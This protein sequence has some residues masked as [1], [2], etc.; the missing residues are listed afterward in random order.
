MRKITAGVLVAFMSAFYLGCEEDIVGKNEVL[1]DAGQQQPRDLSDTGDNS[2]VR[3]ER[4]DTDSNEKIVPD[5]SRDQEEPEKLQINATVTPSVKETQPLGDIRTEVP[6]NNNSEIEYLKSKSFIN[7]TITPT[8]KTDKS[9]LMNYITLRGRTI[10]TK[11]SIPQVKKSKTIPSAAAPMNT[12]TPE[13]LSSN[14]QIIKPTI[15]PIVGGGSKTNTS[16]NIVTRTPNSIQAAKTKIVTESYQTATPVKIP[17][18]NGRP[19]TVT[20]TPTPTPPP[21][22]TPTPTFTPT[23]TP[24]PTYLNAGSDDRYGV[25]L[26]NLDKVTTESFLR[27]LGVDW[28]YGPNQGLVNVPSGAKKILVTHLPLDSAPWNSLST[29]SLDEETNQSIRD[30][31]FLDRNQIQSL[32]IESPGSYWYLYGELNR[33]DHISGELF[34]EVFY[35]YQKQIR[36]N[37]PSAKIIGPSILNWAYTCNGC[38]GISVC[39]DM[40]VFG[41]QCGKRWV[42]NF[43]SEYVSKYDSPPIVDIWAIDAYP[44]DWIITPNT[45]FHAD[46]AIEQIEQYRNFLDT[47]QFDGVVPYLNDP[48]WVMEIGVHVG[49]DGWEF[50][51]GKINPV[52]DYNW[53]EMGDYLN[54]VLGWLDDNS[55]N[56]NIGKWFVYRSWVD[57]VNVGPDGYMGISLFDHHELTEQINC[58]GVIFKT[59]AQDSPKVSCSPNGNVIE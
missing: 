13:K 37:D 26:H 11:T 41:Y 17:L 3:N 9:K 21:T 36:L 42:E 51:N 29:T 50:E 52:G 15:T 6:K 32:A 46:I 56:L 30:M 47:Y 18:Y 8:T 44:I 22:P 43:L 14:L 24:T 12:P 23:V 34:A 57:V 10:I 38:S 4:I 40:Y 28:Y 55:V 20:P 53:D 33:F 19:A 39:D 54:A 49:Y 25:I 59:W 16:R 48:I 2:S 1:V 58:L 5:I 7:P 45:S 27:E 31:G 35:Y